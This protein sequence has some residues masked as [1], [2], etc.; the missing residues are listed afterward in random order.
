MK[1]NKIGVVGA[2]IMGAGIAQVCAQSGYQTIVSEIN[3][4][5]LEK[6][7]NTI[8]NSLSKAVEKGKIKQSDM[9]DTL[10]R[11]KGTINPKDFHDCDLIIEAATEN[12][13]IKKKI[14]SELDNICPSHTI[15]ATNS[16][17]LSLIDIAMVTKRPEKFLGIHFFNPV[18]LMRLIELIRTIVTSDETINTS[19]EICKSFGKSIIIAKDQPGY[20]VNRLLMPYLIEAVKMLETGYATK[21]D[22]DQGAKLGLNY[23]MGPLELLDLIGLDTAYYICCAIYEELKNPQFAP[24]LL[25]KKMVT[26]GQLGRKTGKGFYEYK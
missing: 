1:I 14:F 2:G 21:E 25:L 13:E 6:G 24:P 15:L 3:E 8:K 22:I 12:M 20:I 9:D 16:S 5:L 26:A 18:P 10:N 4:Q 23:P 7:L 19:I 17:C 11:L